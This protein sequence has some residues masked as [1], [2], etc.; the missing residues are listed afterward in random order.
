M[1]L[2]NRF[3]FSRLGRR[4][5]FMFIICALLP[6]AS[7][8]LLS[9]HQVK[10][11]LQKQTLVEL[12]QN[13]QIQVLI[14]F[15]NLL[16]LENDLQSV[17]RFWKQS[18]LSESDSGRYNFSKQTE[19]R[20]RAISIFNREPSLTPLLGSSDILPQKLL[21]LTENLT[22]EKTTIVTRPAKT[23]GADIFL[24]R[25]LNHENPEAGGLIGEVNPDFIFGDKLLNLLPTATR[26]AVLGRGQQIVFSTFRPE[27]T[28]SGLSKTGFGEHHSGS[29]EMLSGQQR[30]I[31]S[32][33][34]IFL[35]GYF[36]DSPLIVI[37]GKS[38]RQVFKPV[39]NFLTLSFLVFIATLL[40]IMLF[41]V[42][43][44]QKSLLPLEK[45]QEGTRQ[46]V[47][48]NFSHQVEVSGHDEFSDLAGAFNLMST[49][50]QRQFK[51]LVSR[52]E[53]NRAVLS[54]LER[55]EIVKTVINRTG[56]F[57]SCES[58]GLILINDRI[59]SGYQA[60]I[61]S[62][63]ETIKELN[64]S[65]EESDLA[66]LHSCKTFIL[67]QSGEKCPLFF[68][69]L[70]V[71][72]EEQVLVFPVF[73]NGRLMAAMFFIY[74]DF[75]KYMQEELV[76]AQQIV[77]QVGVA[78]ANSELLTDLQEM[79]W[80]SLRAFARTVDAKS[81]WTAGHA[82]RVTHLA[83]EIAKFMGVCG[84]EYDNLHRASLLHD[85]GKIGIPLE[86]LNK[87]GELDPEEFSLIKAHP[88]I[89]VRILDP[90]KAYHAFIP[91]IYEHHERFD[92]KGYPAGKKG[93]EIC[94]KARIIA[95]ADVYD[96]WISDRPYR[97]GLGHNKV[98]E[99]IR[100]GAGSD[101]DPEVV[102]AFLKVDF[103]QL[104]LKNKSL[105]V[106]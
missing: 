90:I 54:S 39:K 19:S 96:A 84:E 11:Q 27:T 58:V 36:S 2:A 79:N 80:G 60:F 37:L 1:I 68:P 50:L 76:L 6:L 24:I 105:K 63:Q 10:S 59:N 67:F 77:E 4:I 73:T 47:K 82:I 55:D 101:F 20:F 78:L 52:S 16:M 93:E 21:E 15:E 30:N 87:P 74:R 104:Y 91:A 23:G 17:D 100:E 3:F 49:A 7:I 29:F 44:I 65:L 103:L 92:G 33:L 57:F 22:S 12:K 34:S 85:I 56:D 94:L 69:E 99:I 5:F 66:A 26:M 8:S 72:P 18:S 89:G 48:R 86:L 106:L 45:L 62:G 46:I 102:S 35:E 40:L 43:I 9:M 38:R 28:F 53:I 25:L 61:G 14:I 83:L 64:L 42:K 41:S 71:E 31:I 75:D 70:G 51:V 97:A 32:Y 98:V 88:E 95:V 81:P 13:C